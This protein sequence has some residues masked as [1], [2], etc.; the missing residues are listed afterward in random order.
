M[1]KMKVTGLQ[2][3]TKALNKHGERW[4][5][6][7]YTAA[8]IEGLEVYWTARPFTPQLTGAL[9]WSAGVTRP[10]SKR[11]YSFVAYGAKYAV[12]VHERTNIPHRIGQSKYLEAAYHQHTSGFKSRL[13]SNMKKSYARKLSPGMVN[14][15]VP[16]RPRYILHGRFRST[17]TAAAPATSN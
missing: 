2:Q 1:I 12:H 6:A 11:P 15:E 3:V 16:T 5:N 10:T 9:R 4:E 14:T 8:Y 17:A 7:A 13:I